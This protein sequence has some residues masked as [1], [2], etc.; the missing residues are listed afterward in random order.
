MGE[1]DFILFYKIPLLTIELPRRRFQTYIPVFPV[2]AQTGGYFSCNVTPTVIVCFRSFLAP[3]WKITLMIEMK[4]VEDYCAASIVLFSF[5]L[6]FKHVIETLFSATMTIGNFSHLI[7]WWNR[8]SVVYWQR[9][10]H[11]GNGQFWYS[12]NIRTAFYCFVSHSAV[13]DRGSMCKFSKIVSHVDHM[14]S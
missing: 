9:I 14:S 6:W 12:I 5:S 4:P 10:F 3:R 1:G 13:K 2:R 8:C 7:L 11:S